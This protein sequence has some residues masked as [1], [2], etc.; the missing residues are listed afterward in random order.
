MP[1]LWIW[2]QFDLFGRHRRGYDV[3]SAACHRVCVW[4]GASLAH[5][6]HDQLDGRPSITWWQRLFGAESISRIQ[7]LFNC[8]QFVINRLSN[9]CFSSIPIGICCDVC[10]KPKAP[11]TRDWI[12]PMHHCRPL[13]SAQYSR[14]RIIHLYDLLLKSSSQ[15][16]AVVDAK[17]CLSFHIRIKFWNCFAL[18]W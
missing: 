2:N 18:N 15:T 16:L 10:L 7:S 1:S 11:Y 12:E 13:R 9:K 3:Y 6:M 14:T 17:D 8:L 5:W 4:S